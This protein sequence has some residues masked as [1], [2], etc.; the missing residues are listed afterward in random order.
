L[1]VR[2]VLPQQHG[3]PIA[4]QP[5]PG[6]GREQRQQRNGFPGT[7]RNFLSVWGAQLEPAQEIDAPAVHPV[8]HDGGPRKENVSSSPDPI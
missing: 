7:Q 2:H 5:L 6:R 3:Y 8:H 4:R 1:R